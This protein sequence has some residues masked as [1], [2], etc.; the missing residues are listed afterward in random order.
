MIVEIDVVLALGK[1]IKNVAL[2]VVGVNAAQV[3]VGAVGSQ[4][5]GALFA[6]V[7]APNAVI[8]LRI[9][10]VETL[11]FPLSG[12]RTVAGSVQA[13]G[14]EQSGAADCGAGIEQAL[15]KDHF[16][17]RVFVNKLGQSQKL[18]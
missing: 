8:P 4:K 13:A 9:D 3:F 6:D 5:S 14:V 2:L 10:G 16:P 18:V 17:R 1:S 11:G 15:A 12:G 7:I